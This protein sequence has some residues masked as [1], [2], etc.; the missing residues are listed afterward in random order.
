MHGVIGKFMA[1]MKDEGF[2]GFQ[3]DL[4]LAIYDGLGQGFSSNDNELS[5]VTKLCEI[6]NDKS[7][8]PVSIRAN[9]IHGKRS[10][11]KFNYRDKPTTKEFGD[12]AV[13]TIVSSGR[14][15]LFQKLCIIQN[16]KGS[17]I[18]SGKNK[19][20]S[21][22]D[23]DLEQ[24]Y[25]LKNF[26][27]LSGNTGI[28][29]HCHDVSFRNTGGCLGAFGLMH[30]PGDMI[31]MTAP[32]LTELLKGRK[33]LNTS[34]ISVIVDN[35][36]SSQQGGMGFPFF[37]HFGPM[38]LSMMFKELCHHRKGMWPFMEGAMP[39]FNNVSFTRDIYDFVR[40]WTQVNIGETSFS[41]GEVT[42]A[43]VDGFSNALLRQMGFGDR[44]D[45]PVNRNFA[46]FHW[47]GELGIAVTH[48]DIE[49]MG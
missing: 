8:G 3:N 9:K 41:F 19:G 7:Y 47:E 34:D 49:K 27:K 1:L 33:S 15:R 36:N 40:S 17:E 45:L 12:M 4:A 5:L 10:W 39:F 42:N 20:N 18:T 28:F 31:L 6:T 13:I 21:H 25:L 11:V 29:N 37:G 14:E 44:I 26:P 38:E 43:V 23:I 35:C 46:E 32:L 22:W 48:I 30:D 2:L 16:K 24:L